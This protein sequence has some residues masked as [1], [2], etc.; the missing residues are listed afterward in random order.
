MTALSP[1]V[2]RKKHYWEEDSESSPIIYMNDARDLF[3]VDKP[4]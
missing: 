3:N 4:K 2:I 1:I